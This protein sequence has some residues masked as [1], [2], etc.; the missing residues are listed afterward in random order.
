M[1]VAAGE[2]IRAARL[3]AAADELFAATGAKRWPA[4]RLGG[5]VATDGLRASLGEEAF[6][7]AWAVGRGLSLGQAI[8]EATAGANDTGSGP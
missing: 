2:P 4:E 1:A 7:A 5:P 3:F 6:A 8:D